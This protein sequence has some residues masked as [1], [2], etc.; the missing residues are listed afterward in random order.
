ML[1][2]IIAFVAAAIPLILFAR[3]MFFRRPTRISEGLKEFR[4]QVDFAVWIFLGLVACVALFAAGKLAW[5]WWA[6]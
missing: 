6:L 4:R 3:K 5:T 1:L 2:K